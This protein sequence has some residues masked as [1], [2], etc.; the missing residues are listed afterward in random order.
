[1]TR[2]HVSPA[3]AGRMSACRGARTRA[4]TACLLWPPCCCCALPFVYFLFF[5]PSSP[6]M[7][8]CGGPLFADGCLCFLSP[9]PVPL[10]HDRRCLA[11]L[12][13][14]ER[15]I[16]ANADT[17]SSMV[18]RT[19][20]LDGFRPGRRGRA[21]TGVR[22]QTDGH[23]QRC[24]GS[25]SQPRCTLDTLAGYCQLSR[26]RANALPER[27]LGCLCRIRR[28]HHAGR[29]QQSHWASPLGLPIGPPFCISDSV[30]L[31]AASHSNGRPS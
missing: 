18:C 8:L 17:E 11:T 14:E 30:Q 28:C 16:E 20:P 12:A 1:M 21:E 5:N 29:S 25:P 10:R 24:Q 6:F 4:C 15:W 9:A 27:L 3:A 23:S 13:F 19:V 26:G 22:K 2:G 31:R 7:L